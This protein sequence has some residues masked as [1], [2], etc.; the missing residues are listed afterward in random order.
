M[1]VG[2]GAEIGPHRV[3]AL[4]FYGESR[5]VAF[6][7]A[8]GWEASGPRR[9]VTKSAGHVLFEPAGQPALPLDQRDLGNRAAGLL[10][11]D[12]LLPQREADD[13]LVCT[14]LAPE[15]RPAVPHPRRR[16]PPGRRH[17]AH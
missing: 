1:L 3:V 5:H 11:P 2:L 9:L 6:G 10:F 16:H 17:A 14:I 7:S 8:G 13:G 4:G 12:G 15:R